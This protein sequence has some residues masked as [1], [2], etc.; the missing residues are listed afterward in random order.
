MFTMLT[1]FP[2]AAA[3]WEQL[4][5]LPAPNGG[6]GCGTVGNRIVIV[7]GTNWEGGTKN[8]LREIHEFDPDHRRWGKIK[9]LDDGPVAYAI[10]LSSTSPAGIRSFGLI[11]GTNGTKPLRLLW[12]IDGLKTVARPVPG[13][14]DSVVLSAG[15]RIG[16]IVIIAGGTNDAANV[17]GFR[18]AVVAVE[19]KESRWEV[20]RLPDYPGRPFGIAASAV[21]GRELFIFGG[22]NWDEATKTVINA[23][24]AHA[25][26]VE[27]NAWR[28]LKPLPFAARGVTAVALDDHRIYLAGGYKSDPEGFTDEALIYDVKADSYQKARPLPYAAMVGLVA[29]DGF[30]YCLGGEDKMKSRTNKFYRIP[31][32]EFT[33]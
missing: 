3:E 27:T 9:S 11:G 15:G 6:F 20:R 31:I 17:P 19:A 30:V 22:A 24:E 29:L 5:A 32:A 16:D 18:K 14:P 28:K 33:K 21:I 12:T 2:L 25:F 1:A 13:L 8:W 7:G 4:P 23:S 10:H 26:S